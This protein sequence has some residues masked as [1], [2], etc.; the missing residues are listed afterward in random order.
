MKCFSGKGA[1]KKGGKENRPKNQKN[2]NKKKLSTI[3]CAKHIP[4]QTQKF[5]SLWSL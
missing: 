4:Q 1:F 3:G 5:Q 2:N